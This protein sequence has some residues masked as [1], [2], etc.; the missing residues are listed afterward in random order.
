MYGPESWH[1][2]QVLNRAKRHNHR[3]LINA[4]LKGSM[5]NFPHIYVDNAAHGVMLGMKQLLK[6]QIK[7]KENI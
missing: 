2:M 3:S 5:G 7:F 1:I 6:I 4:D